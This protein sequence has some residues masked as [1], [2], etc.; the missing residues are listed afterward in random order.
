MYKDLE[1]TCLANAIKGLEFHKA[2]PLLINVYRQTANAA[3]AL[4]DEIRAIEAEK[5]KGELSLKTIAAAFALST[6]IAFLA[7]TWPL[8][9]IFG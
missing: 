8:E 7:P 6:Y 4:F 2:I 1:T 5:E 9:M 3:V